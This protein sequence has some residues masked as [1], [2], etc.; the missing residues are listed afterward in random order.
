MTMIFLLLLG[1]GLIIG[2]IA[3][4]AFGFTIPTLGMLVLLSFGAILVT[5]SSVLLAITKLYVKTNANEAFVRNGLAGKKLIKDGGAFF[6]AAVHRLQRVP[7]DSMIYQVT[8]SG[9]DAFMTKDRVRVDITAEFQVRV[10]SDE[11]NIKTA[12]ETLGTALE[13]AA[14]LQA[15]VEPKLVNA[16]RNAAATIELEKLYTD[17][18][19]F[20][21]AVIDAVTSDLKVNGLTLDTATISRLDQTLLEGLRADNMFDAEGIRTIT[22][23]TER[24]K[25]EAN[26]FRRDG[27][28]ARKKQDVDQ[29]RRMLELDQQQKVAEATQAATV[30]TLQAEKEREAQQAQIER[31]RQLALAEVDKERATMVAQREQES[32]V[33]VA[34]RQKQQAVTTAEQALEVARRAKEEA[35]AKAEAQRAASEAELAQAETAREKARQEVKTV[36]VTAEAERE[37]KKQLIKAEADAQQKLIAAQRGADADAYATLKAADARQKAAEAEAVAVTRKATAEADAKRLNAEADQ[38]VQLI[39][40]KVKEAEVEVEKRNVEEV[41]KPTLQARQ[42]SGAVA[43]EF[44]LSQ[45]RIKMDA[46]VRIETARAFA[47]MGANIDAKVFG[48]PETVGRMLNSMAAGMGLAETMDSFRESASSQTLESLGAQM[49]SLAALVNGIAS[50]FG[51]DS[52]ALVS[53]L[54]AGSKIADEKDGVPALTTK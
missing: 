53:R 49:T 22:E 20:L 46:E 15:V 21:K 38:T 47:S 29:A 13:S 23:K 40:I 12:A 37:Q 50:R 54:A 17:R 4:S 32:A 1:I 31:D 35:I 11:E 44:E 14:S 39:P 42:E 30:A 3:A 48:T 7:L 16:L 8:R 10:G 24:M 28:E 6:I 18:A 19:A 2:P 52:A 45:L 27:E 9:Q 33:E 43:Q 5:V 26:Q 34:E 36:E 25:T 41:L 51:I